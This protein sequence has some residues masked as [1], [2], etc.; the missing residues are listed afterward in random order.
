MRV[1]K[2]LYLVALPAEVKQH[3]YARVDRAVAHYHKYIVLFK[4]QIGLVDGFA[5]YFDFF[6]LEF[7]TLA[8]VHID[9]F[10][11]IELEQIAFALSID[12]ND[13]KRGVRKSAFL[14]NGQGLNDRFHALVDVDIV[15]HHG[16]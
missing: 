4:P 13:G 9:R 3:S 15:R 5:E 12:V 7:H 14:T 1:E 10:W 2:F 11:V 8:V 6:A 16:A